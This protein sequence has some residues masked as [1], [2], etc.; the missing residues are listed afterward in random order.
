MV[1]REGGG[2]AVSAVDAEERVA[3][4]EAVETVATEAVAAAAMVG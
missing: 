4:G 1:A 2:V 3:K